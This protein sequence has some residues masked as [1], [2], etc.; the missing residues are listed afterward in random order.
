MGPHFATTSFAGFLCGELQQ[1]Y[2][3]LAS[4]EADPTYPEG[5]PPKTKLCDTPTGLSDCCQGAPKTKICET[6]TGLSDCCQQKP[7]EHPPKHASWFAGI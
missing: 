2:G 1:T 7:H 4:K 5:E 6:P 3:Y